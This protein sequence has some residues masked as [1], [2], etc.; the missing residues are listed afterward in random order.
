MKKNLYFIVPLIASLI[1][2]FSSCI[3]FKRDIVINKDGSG[4]EHLV[5]TFEKLFY[6]MI[7]SMTAFMDSSRQ[8]GFLDSLYNDEIFMKENLDKYDSVPGFNL[9]EFSSVTNS[10][11]SKSFTFKYEF[12]SV[13]K[14]G[15]SVSAIKAQDS[16]LPDATIIFDNS[17]K[18]NV[19]FRFDYSNRFYQDTG[20]VYTDASTDSLTAEMM[21]GMAEMFEGGSIEIAIEFPYNIVSSNA[22]STYGK[23][24]FWN[25]SMKNLIM[26]EKLLLEAVMK[27]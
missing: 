10:D 25:S 19:I 1:F 5:I 21:K 8:E 22:D 3:S 18:E 15:K 11:S 23:K 27:E 12:D 4:T 6:V 26:E 2:S 16:K 17:D 14:I 20:A 9:L 13:Y 24:L 7:S